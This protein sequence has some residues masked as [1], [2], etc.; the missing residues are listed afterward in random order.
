[1]LA[2]VPSKKIK[3]KSA[4]KSVVPWHVQTTCKQLKMMDGGRKYSV[5]AAVFTK[6]AT[7]AAAATTVVRSVYWLSIYW[8]QD[9]HTNG[10]HNN[11]KKLNTLHA[12][13]RQAKLRENAITRRFSDF[14][15]RQVKRQ[16]QEFVYPNSN[17]ITCQCVTDLAD[18]PEYN[19]Y[20]VFSEKKP[21]D[22][23]SSTI[24]L[25]CESQS[26]LAKA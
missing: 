24:I 10:R 22:D 8:L 13:L 14:Y 3:N 21:K 12:L 17:Q 18:L 23:R 5:C 26:V 20:L 16:R 6:T 25:Q 2:R 4:Q 11:N 9:P 19:N 15:R 1:M 7:A